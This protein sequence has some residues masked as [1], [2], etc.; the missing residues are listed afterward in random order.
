VKRTI[1]SATVLLSTPSWANDA[2]ASPASGLA[3]MIFG[4]AI[5]LGLIV[6][7]GWLLRRFGAGPAAAGSLIRVVTA[8][9]VG[10]RE[11][12]V[13][14]E[15]HDTWLVL[16]VAPGRVNTLHQL[17]RQ[18]ITATEP[19]ARQGFAKWLADA[20]RPQPPIPPSASE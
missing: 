10:P 6:L 12:V 20:R 4:L 15:V 17:P 11:R 3:Q 18:V 14:V 7:A 9:S 2:A 16:G 1:S 8:A 13:V 5:V 19:P